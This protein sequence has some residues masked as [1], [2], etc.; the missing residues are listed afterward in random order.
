MDLKNKNIVFIILIV[1][2]LINFRAGAQ[3]IIINEIMSSNQET[4]KDED[5]DFNDWLELKNVGEEELNLSGY[6]LSDKTDKLTSWQFDPNKD[7][8]IPPGGYLLIWAD[9]EPGEGKLH[10][11]FKLSS[12]G[13]MI[14][15]TEPDGV[16]IVNQVKFPQIMTDVS[17]GRKLNKPSKWVYFISPTP[18]R[19]NNL[20]ISSYYW[21]EKIKF[22]AE[23]K[24]IISLFLISFFIILVLLFSY[25]KTNKKLEFSKIKYKNLFEESPIG[26]MRCDIKG[27]ILEVNKE[28]IELLGAPNKKEVKKFN[29]NNIEKIK[30]IW[31]N[32]FLSSKNEDIFE[33]NLEY[34]T[35]WGKKVFLKY[36][37]E[38]ILSKKNGSE[39][40]I[41]ANDIS[42]EKEIEKNLKYFSFHDELTNLYNRR[43]FE[44]EIKRLDTKRKLP[45]SIIIAD[46]NGLKIINDSYGHKKGDEILIQASQ[47][48]KESLR[49]EDI[50][51]RYGG[52]EFAVLLPNTTKETAEKINKRIKEKCK[53]INNNP[54]P[55]SIALGEATKEKP[56]QDIK[57]ILKKADDKMYK[58]KLSEEFAR[59]PRGEIKAR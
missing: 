14:I 10:T 5:S 11:N 6:Y 13:E 4:I 53:K 56:E 47:I 30:D 3:D 52:D 29:L 1:V 21:T 28:M 36:K 37:I 39:I 51:A 31:N 24:I 33:G 22:L 54:I 50:L 23:N 49:E 20:G 27:N 15:L 57:E 35:N 45:I 32:D 44:N 58:D 43:Y 25:Y 9:E 7:F 2:F 34:T 18:E 16:S 41:A 12:S 40:I 59:T 42:R 26:L 38:I 48:L 46:L 8:I 17:F 55:I 19:K